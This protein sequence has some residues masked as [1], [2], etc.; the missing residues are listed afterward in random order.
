MLALMLA[1]LLSGAMGQFTLARQSYSELYHNIIIKARF[2]NGPSYEKALKI[3]ESGY[4]NSPYYE[5]IKAGE[6][7]FGDKQYIPCDLYFSSDLK[8]ITKEPVEYLEGYDDAT[9]FTLVDRI[10]LLPVGFMEEMGLEL[11]D[12]VELN[13]Q[14]YMGIIITYN[15]NYTPEQ[16]ES[17]YHSHAVN[18]KVVGRIMTES[19][20]DTACIPIIA[21]SKFNS[22][23]Y[24]LV[25]DLAEYNLSD[26]HKADEFRKYAQNVIDS[27]RNDP[28]LFLMDTGEA[29][30]IYKIY[31]L[32]ETLYPIAVVIAVL[33]G[34]VL[35]GLIII[36]S[37]R[38]AS[39][40][41]VLGTT[42]R[43]T[44]VMLIFEQLLLCLAGL[45][46]AFAVLAVINGSGI[47]GVAGSI[48]FYCALHFIGCTIGTTIASIVVTKRKILELL[49]VKE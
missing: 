7:N 19:I 4:V 48:G 37:A 45:I 47:L 35:P 8:R 34:A 40:L 22:L 18:C 42:K 46:L 32:I 24:P 43:R 44:R 21:Q 28:P 31:R 26:Y 1:L 10:C 5:Y 11:G 30:N 2:I 9:V 15:P 25:L 12:I 33:I 36:Q 38:E 13:A 41:R 17:A 6:A 20:G 16:R 14:G 3:A 39:I 29:D 49:Q 23:L 27:I